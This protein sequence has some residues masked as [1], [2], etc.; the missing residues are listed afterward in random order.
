MCNLHWCYTFC[1]D[2]TL[3]VLVLHLNCTALLMVYL[4]LERMEYNYYIHCSLTHSILFFPGGT[5]VV[6]QCLPPDPILSSVFHFPP[7]K[8]SLLHLCH[9]CGLPGVLGYG[10][11]SLTN[12]CFECKI[13]TCHNA[14][15]ISLNDPSQCA[16]TVM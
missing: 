2:V 4:I 5:Q 14:D 6:H 9:S 7:L 1:T 11:S 12:S 13:S 10:M 15:F 3:F 16:A 8:L